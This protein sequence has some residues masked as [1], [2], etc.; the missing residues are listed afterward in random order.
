MSKRKRKTLPIRQGVA[1]ILALLGFLTLLGELGFTSVGKAIYNLMKYPLGE[2]VW[3]A[4]FIFLFWPLVYGRLHFL[5]GSRVP[6]QREN[7][8]I[9]EEEL[10][11]EKEQ[12]ERTFKKKLWKRVSLIKV[13]SCQIV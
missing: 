11:K 2:K 1:V 12:K 7:N 5:S 6:G 8:L 13:L 4:P 10:E 3:L 9:L